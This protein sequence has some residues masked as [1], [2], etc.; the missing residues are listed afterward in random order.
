LR[1]SS[2]ASDG[3]VTWIGGGTLGRDPGHLVGV[4]PN[5]GAGYRFEIQPRANARLDAGV[6]RKSSGIYFSFA[7]A[8]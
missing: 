4:L 7:E 3:F 2:A 6:G 1:A 5:A 8:F